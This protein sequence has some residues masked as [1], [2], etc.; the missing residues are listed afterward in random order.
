VANT[1]VINNQQIPLAATSNVV[2]KIRDTRDP[3]IGNV[4]RNAA[5][6]AAVAAGISGLAGD[7][8][9]TP[10][11]VLTGATAGAAI[12]TN[13]GR[14]ASS[15]VRDSLIGAALATGASAVI[16]DRQ[17][18]PEKV[19]TGAAAGATIGGAIDPAVRRVVVIDANTD[20]GLTLTQSFTVTP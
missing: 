1:V 11:K 17:I 2:K 3:N 9:I 5:I 15:V 19:I 4:F 18:T 12:E 13:Q 10:L 6:G 8:T 7:R 20:L 14:P 16:G